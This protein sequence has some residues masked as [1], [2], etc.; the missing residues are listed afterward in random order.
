M[1]LASIINKNIYQLSNT[2][3]LPPQQF[4]FFEELGEMPEKSCISQVIL[5][6]YR[7]N[8]IKNSCNLYEPKIFQ[9]IEGYPFLFVHRTQKTVLFIQ[10]NIDS[11]YVITSLGNIELKVS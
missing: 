10:K 8:I 3:I 11:T 7:A 1:I 6:K 9:I 5:I 4:H 2:R